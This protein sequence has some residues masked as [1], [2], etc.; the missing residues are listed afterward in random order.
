MGVKISQMSDAAALT[1]DELLELVQ[2][3]TNVKSTTAILAALSSGHPAGTISVDTA[4]AV[5]PTGQFAEPGDFYDYISP[6]RIDAGV[7]VTVT[8][9]TGTIACTKPVMT[10]G[11]VDGERIVWVNAGVNGT[12]LVGSDFAALDAN[13]NVDSVTGIPPASM[14]ANQTAAEAIVRASF[15]CIL[16]FDGSGGVD[17]AMA[18]TGLHG[19]N[20]EG[21]PTLFINTGTCGR[22]VTTG[23]TDVN[24][25]QGAGGIID[26]SNSCFFG[27]ANQNMV[28]DG[29]GLVT[30][31]NGLSLFGASSCML[32]GFGGGFLAF[33]AVIIGGGDYGWRNNHGGFAYFQQ[34]DANA[35]PSVYIRG[36]TVG[37]EATNTPSMYW[38]FICDIQYCYSGIQAEYGG[39]G[40]VAGGVV[41][42]N[43]RYQASCISGGDLDMRGVDMVSTVLFAVNGGAAAAPPPTMTPC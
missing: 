25:T 35:I 33:N 4:F 36:C 13:W 43:A 31:Y 16:E 7:T 22:G 38:A 29:A 34:Q 23:G 15:K 3:G 19:G 14:A 10:A 2:N 12:P 32:S 41:K 9:Q 5:G 28:T 30:F 39:S 20:W 26:L 8:L 1:G 6:F 42:N 18:L 11:H 24:K 21:C 40:K 27:F 37:M 17:T